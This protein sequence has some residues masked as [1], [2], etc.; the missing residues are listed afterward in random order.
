MQADI[1]Q[2]KQY[3]S[4]RYPGR[5]TTKHYMSDLAIFFDFVGAVSLKEVT[6]K[7]IYQFVQM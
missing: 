5:S 3:L 6:V 1:D 4:H 7:T 2:F